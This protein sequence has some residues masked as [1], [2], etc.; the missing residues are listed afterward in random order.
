M[1]AE[2]PDDTSRRET[3]LLRPPGA[4]PQAPAGRSQSAQT[5]RLPAPW[6]L[7]VQ[8]AG[9][10]QTSVGL[11]VKSE[12]ILGR[13]DPTASTR[14]D[15]DLTPYGGQEAGVSRKHVAIL[16]DDQSQA[17]YVEDLNSTNGTRLNGFWL[18]AGQRYRLRD[19]DRLEL[20]DLIL[21]L[22]FA[23]SPYPAPR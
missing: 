16:R 17:L 19:G 22:R 20:G 12:L 9:P 10:T 4:Q 6:R 18:D 14:P 1:A 8:I 7:L 21:T 13:V 15:L 11:E 5:G 23:R 3:T 2:K